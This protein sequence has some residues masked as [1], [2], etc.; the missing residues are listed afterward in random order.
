MTQTEWPERLYGEVARAI[1]QARKAAE[2][3]A[4]E[5]AER[6]TALGHPFTRDTVA[7]LEN[8]RKRIELA[9]LLVIAA[10][11]NTSVLALLSPPPPEGTVELLPDQS[12]N[13]TQAEVLLLGAEPD[14]QDLMRQTVEAAKRSTR[15]ERL[16]H[17]AARKEGKK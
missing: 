12:M 1:V 10:A 4:R 9:D 15:A 8:G 17:L 13:T 5:L 7:N 11:L 3:S 6:A 16:A 2:I 14:W